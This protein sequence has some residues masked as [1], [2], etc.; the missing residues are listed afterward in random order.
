M[1]FCFYLDR[2]CMAAVVQS[3]SFQQEMGLDKQRTGD[4]LASFFFA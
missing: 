1:R 4:I 3:A 2:I